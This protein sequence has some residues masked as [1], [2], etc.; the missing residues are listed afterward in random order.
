M[1]PQ[2]YQQLQSKFGESVV[3]LT[4]ETFEGMYRQIII[5]HQIDPNPSRNIPVVQAG[6]DVAGMIE[7]SD[8]GEV[9]LQKLRDAANRSGP[10]E[11]LESLGGSEGGSEGTQ[12][13]PPESSN[14]PFVDVSFELQGTAPTGLVDVEADIDLQTPDL[15]GPIGGQSL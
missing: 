5:W 3:G 10:V 2:L 9:F 4:F 11:P 15:T 12:P 7:S 8:T 13:S 14:L 1:N 6:I